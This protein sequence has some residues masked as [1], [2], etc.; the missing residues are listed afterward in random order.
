MKPSFLN[1]IF[2]LQKAGLTAVYINLT[3]FNKG[4]SALLMQISFIWY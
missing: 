2:E 4:L 1:A 3:F